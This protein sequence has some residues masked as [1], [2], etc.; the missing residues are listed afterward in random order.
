[1]YLQ[2]QYSKEIAEK[3]TSEGRKNLSETEEYL[4][5]LGNPS[6]FF[7]KYCIVKQ[8]EEDFESQNYEEW[9]EE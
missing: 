4:K 3:I 2:N 7:E 8:K 5:C 1:M 9:T 6:Y